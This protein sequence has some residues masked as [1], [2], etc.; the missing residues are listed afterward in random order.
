MLRLSDLQCANCICV[1]LQLHQASVHCL[2]H[3]AW[4]DHDVEDLHIVTLQ[5]MLYKLCSTSMS[6]ATRLVM[7][8]LGP[9]L[10][11][12]MHMVS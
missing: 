4:L 5:V 9:L 11:P 3:V 7:Y 6:I 2:A 10:M 12:Y 1:D 8:T